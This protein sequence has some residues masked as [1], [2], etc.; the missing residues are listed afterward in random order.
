MRHRCAATRLEVL[1]ETGRLAAGLREDVAERRVP[2]GRSTNWKPCSCGWSTARWGRAS[3][4]ADPA[5][6]AD[7]VL[8]RELA[9]HGRLANVRLPG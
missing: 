5:F 4:G 8:L 7:V 3:S 1:D 6:V 2:N 9:H